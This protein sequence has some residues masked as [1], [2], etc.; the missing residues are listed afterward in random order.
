MTNLQSFNAL[1]RS[2]ITFKLEFIKKPI[3]LLMVVGAM[4]ISP[5]AIAISYVVYEFVAITVNAWPNKKLIDYKLAE[6]IKDISP[7]LLLSLIMAVVVYFVGLLKINVYVLF[8]FQAIVSLAF[9]YFVSK[10][11]RLESYDYIFSLIKNMKNKN[12]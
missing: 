3:S 6:Q 9:Y 11:F 4:M 8:L 10:L 1:G 12:I 2:D 5:I 7:H